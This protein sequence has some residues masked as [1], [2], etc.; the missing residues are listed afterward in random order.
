MSRNH[1]LRVDAA[2]EASVDVDAPHPQRVERQALRRQHVAHPARCRCQRRSPPARQCVEVWLS[3]QAMVMPGL[4]QPGLRADDMD[5]ALVLAVGRPE[6]DA[7]VAAIA[8]ERGHHLFRHHVEERPLLRTGRH[9]VIDGGEGALGERHAPAVLAHHVERLRRRHFMDEV[10]ADEQL[11]MAARQRA[12]R[13]RDPRPSKRVAAIAPGR[14][15]RWVSTALVPD[16]ALAIAAGLVLSLRGQSPPTS[17]R[18][19]I[20]NVGLPAIEEGAVWDQV[21]E[22][23]RQPRPSARGPF[24]RAGVHS[25]RRLR[26]MRTTPGRV[27]V[28]FR[29]GVTPQERLD[30]VRGASATADL[31]A[32]PPYADFDVIG[33]NP[34]EDAERVAAALTSRGRSVHPGRLPRRPTVHAE[35]SRL[36]TPAVEPAAPQPGAGWDIQPQ[37]GSAITVA[38]LD[39]GMAYQTPL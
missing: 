11:C 24:D 14:I 3:P 4:R 34:A 33:I 13:V 32:R 30:M 12:H 31:A 5:D 18:L 19:Q 36:R 6:L 38:V 16:L 26:P 22:R 10:E 29:D 28:R 23:R 9:D 7:R 25:R 20:E 1:V 8:L 37:A 15:Q 35:R 2:A 17:A 27:I 21:R 39:T